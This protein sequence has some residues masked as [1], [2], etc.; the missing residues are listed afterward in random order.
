MSW[1]DWIRLLGAG[2]ILVLLHAEA[3]R[4]DEA[5]QAEMLSH[6]EIA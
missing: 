3:A 2:L 6:Y 5:A 4:R 1:R